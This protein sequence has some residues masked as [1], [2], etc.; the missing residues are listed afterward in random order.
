MRPRRI[1]VPILPSLLC[2]CLGPRKRL[3]R[4]TLGTVYGGQPDPAQIRFPLARA[5]S[6]ARWGGLI[7]DQLHIFLAAVAQSVELGVAQMN[8]ELNRLPRLD[9]DVFLVEREE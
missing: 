9:L 3:G 5:R 2:D 1:N 8:V 7:G 4:R 6:A